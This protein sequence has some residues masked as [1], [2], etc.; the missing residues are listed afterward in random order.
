MAGKNTE[1]WIAGGVIGLGLLYY[2]MS[3]ADAAPPI[4]KPP[5]AP[6]GPLPPGPGPTGFVSKLCP[7][8][9]ADLPDANKADLD[10]MLAEKQSSAFYGQA[11]KDYMAAGWPNAAACLAAAQ[12]VA[13]EREGL[14]Q[15]VPGGNPID[16]TKTCAFWMAQYNNEVSKLN[17][18]VA[19]LGVDPQANAKLEAATAGINKAKA[20]LA[21]LGCP[22]P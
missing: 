5:P 7:N 19:A 12:V 6:P 15:K 13:A 16:Q 17:A 9:E 21:E 14:L 18:A 3:D 4:V 8:V 2:M 20:S 10:A 22:V 11:A 1:V